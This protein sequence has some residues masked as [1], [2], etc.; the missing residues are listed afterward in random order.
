MIAVVDAPAPPAPDLGEVL[1]DLLMRAVRDAGP[2]PLTAADLR[3]L[4][5]AAE[6][7]KVECG[8]PVW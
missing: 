6:R 3:D 8:E 5:A 2:R 4:E 1:A 7:Y